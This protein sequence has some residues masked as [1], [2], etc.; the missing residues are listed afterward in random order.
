VVQKTKLSNYGHTQS[1]E[2][3][4]TLKG[5]TEGVSSVAF[6]EKNGLLASASDDIK[7]WNGLQQANQLTH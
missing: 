6:D 2:L 5:H 7:L 3:L 1:G 4:D